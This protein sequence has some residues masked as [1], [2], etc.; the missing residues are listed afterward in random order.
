MKSLM[1]ESRKLVQ[2][3]E[4]S[5]YTFPTRTPE[6][7]GTLH[8]DKTTC[9]LVQVHAADETGIGYTYADKATGLFI[10]EHL[11][12]ILIGRDPMDIT[13][14]WLEMVRRIRNLGR[15]GI[16]SM[17]ISAVD[18]AL[19]DLK[20]KLLGLPLVMLLG[21]V[22]DR[23]PLYGSGGF[24]TYSD[25]QLADQLGGWAEQGFSRVKMKVGRELLDSS[26]RIQVARNAI[27]PSVELFVD[28]NGAYD[29]KEALRISAVLEKWDV[30][31]FEEPVSSDHLTGLRF[32]KNRF[33]AQIRVAAGE[34]GYDLIY[35]RRM[36][37]AKAIDVLQIDITRCGG[38]TG[39]LQAMAL[40]D[41]F[42]VPISAHCAPSLHLHLACACP[43]MQHVEYFFDHVEIETRIFEGYRQPVQ[44]HMAPDLSRPG[45]GLDLKKHD[46]QKFAA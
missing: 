42:S 8:W 26:H 18:T 30:R 44:G 32:L 31:W 39:Y 24:I 36:L 46:A 33:P 41:S 43:S 29:V 17:A 14:I 12:P 37:E 3:V 13:S 22:R 35:F 15:P 40:A 4:V 38:V 21:K 34:Y 28:G 9:V 45:V 1:R 23:I 16:A 5:V 10:Q 2:K 7:D 27:G 6:S 20:A 25:H 19:W 11:I